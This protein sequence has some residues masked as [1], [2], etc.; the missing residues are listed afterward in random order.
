MQ[1]DF[2]VIGAMKCGTSTACAFLEDH[3]D[4]FMVP[5]SEPNF[6]SID[7]NYATGV[8]SYE[9]LFDA[10]RPLQLKGEGSNSYSSGQAASQS[11]A[12]MAQLYPN[13]KLVYLVRHPVTRIRSEW[14]QRRVQNGDSCP[15]TLDLAIQT[16]PDYF[17]GKS[18]YWQNLSHYR[19]HFS[20]DQ[21]FVSCLE[22]LSTDRVG[23]FERLC[24][25]L[26]IENMTEVKR[27]HVNPSSGKVVPTEL[28]TKVNRVP[29]LSL[30]K[31]LLPKGLKSKVKSTLLSKPVDEIPDFSPAVYAQLVDAV[32]DDSAKILDHLGKPTDFWTF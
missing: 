29:G 13:L 18:L 7:T 11:A 9:K 23:F 6:F 28:Y 17:L 26:E 5:S 8:D 2:L 3:P 20:D 4:V 1:P 22:D 16:Q 10:A 12:R 30:L 31:S 27:G 25:F 32:R 24:G 19:N 14:V 15:A 21:L